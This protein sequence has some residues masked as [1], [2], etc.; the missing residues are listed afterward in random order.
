MK[1]YLFLCLTI[2]LV[3]CQGQKMS[4]GDY[5]ERQRIK[6]AEALVDRV[7]HGRGKNFEVLLAEDDKCEKD[8]F[9]YYS[10]DGKVVLE[11]NDGVSIASA[12]GQ[13]L[14]D[15]CGWHLSWCGKQD[16]LPD[17]FPLPEHK[18]TKVSPYKYRYYLCL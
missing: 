14:K 7:T 9:S 6:A 18:V 12:L 10:R 2:L 4:S 1:R 17:E 5:T 3:A 8:W 16:V 11:G 15:N 13:Y